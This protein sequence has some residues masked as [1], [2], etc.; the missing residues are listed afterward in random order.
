[1]REKRDVGKFRSQ[2]LHVG[3]PGDH[4]RQQH[5]IDPEVA[6]QAGLPPHRV[7]VARQ[8]R[9]IAR[10]M[11]GHLR[12][13]RD[14]R[15]RR[16]ARGRRT[17]V[18]LVGQPVIVLDVIDA[19]A[20]EAFGQR[21]KPIR[22]QALRL[23]RR[24]GQGAMRQ[25][26]RAGAGR[27]CRAAARR[28]PRPVRRGAPRRAAPR[29]RAARYCR[30]ACSATAR[31][32]RRS[33]RRPG[34]CARRNGRRRAVRSPAPRRRCRAARRVRRSPPAASRH[35]ARPRLPGRAPRSRRRRRAHGR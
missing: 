19:A 1:M 32:R 28:T 25:R 2:R 18:I 6:R 33:L 24:A 31:R 4:R 27:R 13:A 21:A 15:R 26:R 14:A 5:A 29:R 8:A 34:R 35:F 20:G 22:R 7:E 16:R 12:G 11:P 23:Q 17:G 9:H 30:T 3:E 10:R